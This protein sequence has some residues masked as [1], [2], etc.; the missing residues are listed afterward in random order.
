MRVRRIYV[1]EA[2]HL[3]DRIRL[4]REASHH[5][6]QV[7]RLRDGNELKLFNG[8][9]G[10]Y[11]GII[12]LEGRSVSV[13]IAR[14]EEAHTESPLRVEL[15]QSISR[16]ERMD[17]TIQ[18]SVELGVAA[19]HPVF[20]QRT[21]LRL[22]PKRLARRRDHW[23]RVIINACE[24]C[25]RSELPEL[26]PPRPLAEFLAHCHPAAHPHLLLAP[27]G[28][29]RLE[30]VR[31]GTRAATLLVG[32]EGGLSE[33]EKR[34]A[35]DAGFT[36]LNLGPRVLRTETAAVVALS[37]LQWRWGDLGPPRQTTSGSP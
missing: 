21:V 2:L 19:I 34:Q 20:T 26:H 16:A 23:H 14:F 27:S 13:E 15:V 25:C 35:L 6:A 24:Q 8:R 12:R 28:V 1:P 30:N 37:I 32:P 33:S 4:S 11:I 29:H 22:E 17:Y 10:D 36:S 7:L 5:V 3:G 9:A 18:K 31:E